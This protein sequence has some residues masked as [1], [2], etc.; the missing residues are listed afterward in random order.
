MGHF[1]PQQSAIFSKF[2]IIIF[3]YNF[4]SLYKRYGGIGHFSGA[5]LISNFSL[6]VTVFAKKKHSNTVLSLVKKSPILFLRFGSI[7]P[8]ISAEFYIIFNNIN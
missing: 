6:I 3:S 1:F 5:Y 7:K 4:F 2:F 8:E